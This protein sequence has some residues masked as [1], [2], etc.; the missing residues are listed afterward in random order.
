MKADSLR[1]VIKW[2]KTHHKNSLE[3][4]V[5]LVNNAELTTFYFFKDQL[6]K[7]AYKCLK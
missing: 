5:Q 7:Y 2:A 1:S 6:A 3:L 4:M